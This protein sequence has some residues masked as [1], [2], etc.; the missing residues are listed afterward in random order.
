MD[1]HDGQ[2]DTNSQL[3]IPEAYNGAYLTFVKVHLDGEKMSVKEYRFQVGSYIGSPVC[4]ALA[5]TI[6]SLS[7]CLNCSV[8]VHYKDFC[9]LAQ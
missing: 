8:Q 6:T 3:L 9:L 7:C 4:N 1:L 2:S 5:T